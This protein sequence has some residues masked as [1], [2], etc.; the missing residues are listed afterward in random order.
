MLRYLYTFLYILAA[1][2]LCVRWVYKSFKPP[3]YREPLR[4]RFGI[5]S[6]E[7]SESIWFHAVSMGESNAAIAI[8]KRLLTKSPDLNIIVTTTTPTGARQIHNGLGDKV[9]HHYSP[10]DLPG[11]I[12]RFIHRARPKLL[13]IMETEL[14]PNW[15][16]H[17]KSSQIP[18]ILANGRLSERSAQKYEKVSSLSK[19]MMD[20][21]VKVLAVNNQDAERFQRIGLTSDKATVTGNIKFDIDIPQFSDHEYYPQWKGRQVWIAASTHKGEDELVLKAHQLICEQVPDAR[22]ILV[23][24]HPERFESVARLI[25]VTELR[26]ARRSQPDSWNEDAQVLLGDTMGEMMKAFNISD[27]T[28]VGGSF[29]EIGGHNPIEPAVLAK[30]VLTGPYIFNFN[31]I[32]GDLIAAG[33]AQMVQNEFELAGK[34]VELMQSP[35]TAY[36][37]GQKALQVIERNRGA[38]DKTVS[39]IEQYL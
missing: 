16:H 6:K 33:G 26:M 2:L 17:L 34:I 12:K 10:C 35:D 30:P 24:R 7:S 1:P 11:T 28:W 19:E 27:I 29:A 4:E 14:W 39:V 38:L 31:E 20:A 22:L 3:Q 32:F 37:M 25:S 5:V 9:K 18:V 23:P 21:F 36:D 13:V 15:L 8:I